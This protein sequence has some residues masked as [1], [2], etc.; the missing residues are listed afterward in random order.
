M[1]GKLID[2][3]PRVADAA[4]HDDHEHQHAGEDRP[5]DADSGRATAWSLLLASGRCSAGRAWPLPSAVGSRDHDLL[6]AS[7]TP[8]AGPRRDRRASGP[9]A[10]DALL[11]APVRDDEQRATGRRADDERALAARS[12]AAALP[13]AQLDVGEHAGHAAA[14]RRCR[15]APRRPDRA[16]SRARRRRRSAPCR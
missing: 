4:E 13:D 10:S 6:A 8:A 11:E 3:E 1:F 12:A 9:S 14:A 7:S 16:W 5:P 15:P 2:A